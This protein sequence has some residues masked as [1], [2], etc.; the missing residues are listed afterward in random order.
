MDHVLG[1]LVLHRNVHRM[2]SPCKIKGFP[3]DLHAFSEGL[4]MNV[5]TDVDGSFE[6]TYDKQPLLDTPTISTD[7]IRTN[8]TET[9]F[10]P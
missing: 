8:M 10:G 4:M 6:V 5:H 7:I 1:L 9:A 3:M 2:F